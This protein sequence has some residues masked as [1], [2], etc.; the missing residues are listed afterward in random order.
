MSWLPARPGPAQAGLVEV[1]S[2]ECRGRGW[3]LALCASPSS[4]GTYLSVVAG[5]SEVR[6]LKAFL[7]AGRRLGKDVVRYGT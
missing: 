5:D 6:A 7:W 3:G 4:A 2:S 1:Q